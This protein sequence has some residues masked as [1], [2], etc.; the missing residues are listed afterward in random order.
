MAFWSTQRLLGALVN[1]FSSLSRE[2]PLIIEL[3]GGLLTVVLGRA[4]LEIDDVRAEFTDRSREP[5]FC[6]L[7]VIALLMIKVA[8]TPA[9]MAHGRIIDSS[10]ILGGKDCG[11]RN[12]TPDLDCL[13]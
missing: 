12:R 11:G 4:F 8:A 7:T 6:P 13:E 2:S 9:T 10:L 5:T 1:V 3:P